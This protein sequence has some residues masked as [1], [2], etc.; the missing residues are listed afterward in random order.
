MFCTSWNTV[1]AASRYRT[2]VV[3]MLGVAASAVTPDLR[4]GMAHLDLKAAS[5]V[6]G[7]T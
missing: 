1:N 3:E 2:G 5:W 4:S 6:S 7:V